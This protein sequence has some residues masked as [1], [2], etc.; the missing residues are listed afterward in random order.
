MRELR[1]E[2]AAAEARAARLEE[3]LA[4]GFAE[5]SAMG[6]QLAAAE[7][8][9]AAAAAEKV[10]T[11]DQ[12]SQV[13]VCFRALQGGS[14]HACLSL[15]LLSLGFRPVVPSHDFPAVCAA[16]WWLGSSR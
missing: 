13:C 10:R 8:G 15:L 6:E 14:N 4:A 7:A 12:L 3:S 11:A 2:L 9:R 1:E 5:R 16:L